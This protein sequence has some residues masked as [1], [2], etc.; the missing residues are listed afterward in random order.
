MRY[1][2][3]ADDPTGSGTWLQNRRPDALLQPRDIHRL[4]RQP[5]VTSEFESDSPTV[6][7][8]AAWRATMTI[9]PCAR[10]IATPTAF[11]SWSAAASASTAT[12]RSAQ[13][14]SRCLNEYQLHPAKPHEPIV[15]HA[16]RAR[17]AA[18]APRRRDRL[19]ALRDDHAVPAAGRRRV[20]GGAD[21]HRRRDRAHGVVARVRRRS[22][23]ARACGWVACGARPRPA[24]T[25]WAPAL[26]PAGR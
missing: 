2:F 1:A 10:P 7:A 26:P 12:T 23:P 16:R 21:R 6:A 20:G 15:H 25:A 24:P 11:S 3:V 4:R 19:R 17:R 9:D 5:A 22:R 13:S 14:W 18:R 8:Q